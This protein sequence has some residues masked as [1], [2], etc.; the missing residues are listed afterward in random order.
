MEKDLGGLVSLAVELVDYKFRLD[1][2]SL[3]TDAGV[4]V[5]AAQS[6]SPDGGRD[7]TWHESCRLYGL[8]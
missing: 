2:L 8:Y 4:T 1:N 3:V 5:S 6:L 7:I